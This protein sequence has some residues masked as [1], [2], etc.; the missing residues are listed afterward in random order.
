MLPPQ[1]TN[2]NIMHTF[3]TVKYRPRIPLQNYI[4]LNTDYC[5]T[6]LYLYT[7]S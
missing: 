7:Q 2:R 5:L 6:L 4:S 3:F 1:T